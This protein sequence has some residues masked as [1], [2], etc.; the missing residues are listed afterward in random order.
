MTMLPPGVDPRA[1]VGCKRRDAVIVNASRHEKTYPR[2]RPKAGRRRREARFPRRFLP[3]GG[4]LSIRCIDE[5]SKS[6]AWRSF[7]C[8]QRVENCQSAFGCG[9]QKA[10]VRGSADAGRK[11]SICFESRIANKRTFSA[12]HSVG[13]E[14]RL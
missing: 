4:I 11:R 7:E 13:S 3:T 6:D 12:A 5:W 1:A 9:N 10:D 14:C 2:P 8:L